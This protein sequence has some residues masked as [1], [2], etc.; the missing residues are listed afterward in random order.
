LTPA[1]RGLINGEALATMKSTAYLINTSR[2]AIIDEGAL[3]AALQSGQIAGAALDVMS[4]EPPLPDH[5]LLRHPRVIATPHVAFISEAAIVDLANKAARH[6][7]QALRGEVPDR[8]VNP[9]V[10]QQGNS[11]VRG[12]I[13]GQP[14]A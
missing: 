11:R 12:Q 3:L 7:A 2:G 10:L 6:V 8:V 14:F 1:T 9:G 13:G 5:P 4:S